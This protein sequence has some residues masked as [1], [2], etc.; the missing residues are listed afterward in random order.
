MLVKILEI[1]PLVQRNYN[2]RD[3]REQVF[4]SKGFVMMGA[5][6]AFYAEAIQ[7]WASHWDKQN[8]KKNHVVDVALSYRCRDYTDKE[9]VKR[10]SNELTITNMVLI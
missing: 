6:G 8:L 10:Y 7:E 9:G 2:D 4:V 3:G 5:H 1:M